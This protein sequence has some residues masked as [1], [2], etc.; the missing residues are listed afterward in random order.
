MTR[1]R[2]SQ[3]SKVYR[4]EGASKVKGKFLGTIP[5]IEAYLERVFSHEWFRRHFPH[6][7]RFTVKDG[8]GRRAAGG[9]G[10]GF[11]A[12]ITMPKWSRF[13]TI[14]LH[15][16]AHGLTE[17]EW[18]RGT[19]WHGWEFCETFLKL[20]YHYMG[21]EAGDKLKASFKEHRV[22]FRKP[23]RGRKL[24]PEQREAAVARLAAARE[25]KAAKPR[26]E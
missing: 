14:I 22:R 17:L 23:R 9:S 8:R 16:L 13:E 20:V 5:E 21:R 11:R 4:A 15:E 25:A 3:R 10:Y 24:T 19:A 7:R 18:G 1:E 2:D 26:M 6:A 12:V